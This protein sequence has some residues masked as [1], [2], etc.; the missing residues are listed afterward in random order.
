[1]FWVHGDGPWFAQV[2]VNQ[3]RALPSVCCCH[4][5]GSVA[6][7]GPVEVVLHPVQ[8][9]ALWRVQGRVDQGQLPGGVAG[10]VDV[11]A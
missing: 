6:G 4:R 3:N 9:Q 11:S 8:S 1:M 5:D 10:F 2:A 7:V